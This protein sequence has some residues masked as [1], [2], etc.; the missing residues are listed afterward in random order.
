MR[1]ACSTRFPPTI[2]VNQNAVR[3]SAPIVGLPQTPRTSAFA[4]LL[5]SE[6]EK[7]REE[8]S[9]HRGELEVAKSPPEAPPILNAMLFRHTKYRFMFEADQ[10]EPWPNNCLGYWGHQL[11]A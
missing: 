2:A 7:I 4:S 1:V 6:I 10:Y 9:P 3:P 5:P 11:T 8:V